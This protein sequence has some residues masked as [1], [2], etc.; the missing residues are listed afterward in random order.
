MAARSV[1]AHSGSDTANLDPRSWSLRRGVRREHAS[2]DH[3]PARRSRHV[4]GGLPGR[5]IVGRNRSERGERERIRRLVERGWLRQLLASNG[6][7]RR[8]VGRMHRH[9]ARLPRL[10][11]AE[12]LPSRSDPRDVHPGPLDVRRSRPSRL[13]RYLDLQ[14]RHLHVRRHDVHDRHA[15]LRHH[16][17]GR[18]LRAE[19]PAGVPGAP[20]RLRR[21]HPDVR[22]PASRR[23]GFG[24][25]GSHKLHPVLRRPATRELPVAE[26]LR[27]QD[28]VRPSP[29]RSRPAQLAF[30]RASSSRS[31]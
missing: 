29:P 22:L 24:L 15:V 3:R 17:P 7:R 13:R 2:Y 30:N 26:S 12:L 14:R 21:R 31:V 18:G 1:L 23:A 9:R 19:R 5:R 4:A 8:I 20:Y 28:Y 25:H 10:R 11:L 16:G 6:Q 27:A